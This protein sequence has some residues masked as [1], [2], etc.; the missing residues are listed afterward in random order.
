MLECVYEYN[1]VFDYSPMLHFDEN[2]AIPV[3]DFLNVTIQ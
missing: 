2:P 3:V 1:Y